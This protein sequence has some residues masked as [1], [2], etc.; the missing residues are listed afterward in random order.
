MRNGRGIGDEESGGTEI[1]RGKRL[2][3]AERKGRGAK[4]RQMRNM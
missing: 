3:T 2:G 4:K 1:Q